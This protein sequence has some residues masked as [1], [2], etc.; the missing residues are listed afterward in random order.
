VVATQVF[1]DAR[2]RSLAVLI[3]DL[4][5]ETRRGSED[6]ARVA[7]QGAIRDAALAGLVDVARDNGLAIR[8]LIAYI[9][10]L[11]REGLRLIILP[12][13]KYYIM[14]KSLSHSQVDEARPR[15]EAI[16]E[17]RAFRVTHLRA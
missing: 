16:E 17:D 10:V 1:D 12:S 13:K 6:N 15:A 8:R 7:F 14:H 5:G 3:A 9:P 11:G 4:L 2:G